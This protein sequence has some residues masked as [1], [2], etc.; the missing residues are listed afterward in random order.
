MWK[1]LKKKNRCP[2][3]TKISN[4]INKGSFK[5]ANTMKQHIL[6]HSTLQFNGNLLE[7]TGLADPGNNV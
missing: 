3:D 6:H 5:Q 2:N 1:E 7:T 4:L